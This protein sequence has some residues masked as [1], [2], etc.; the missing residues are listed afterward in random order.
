[1]IKKFL[2][3]I[4]AFTL[5]TLAASAADVWK[6]YAVDRNNPTK[7]ITYTADSA[8][9]TPGN[10][11]NFVIEVLNLG[12]A[13]NTAGAQLGDTGTPWDFVYPIDLDSVSAL[14]A[15]KLKELFD[16]PTIAISVG[17]R[18]D[19]A[20]IVSVVSKQAS[21]GHATSFL[22]EY[23][24]K[25]GDL[26]RPLKIWDDGAGAFEYTA[27][28][29]TIGIKNADNTTV[30][31]SWEDGVPDVGNA[32]G[33]LPENV[34][35]PP[36]SR[37]NKDLSLS[38]I[39]VEGARF[40]AVEEGAS[41]DPWRS[42]P[43]NVP[44]SAAIE[45]TGVGTQ[46]S[47]LYVWSDNEDILK[48]NAASNI[49]R[50]VKPEAGKHIIYNV[51]DET[52]VSS[53]YQLDF[54]NGGGTCGFTL[55]AQC[56]Y[57]A[58]NQKSAKVYMSPRIGI[59]VIEG[60]KYK[61]DF[62]T[63]TVVIA[64]PIQTK[65]TL[66]ARIDSFNKS[67]VVIGS[68]DQ[69]ALTLNFS[70]CTFEENIKVKF[71]VSYKDAEGNDVIEDENDPKLIVL[72]G[73]SVT[74]QPENKL[75]YEF[76]P[77]ETKTANRVYFYLKGAPQ[78][79]GTSKDRIICLKPTCY[80]LAGNKIDEV[81]CE[82]AYILVKLEA[83]VLPKIESI[84]AKDFQS[85]K[86]G[87]VILNIADTPRNLAF[88]NG[89]EPE[90][91]KLSA[92]KSYK[93][94]WFKDE[95][96]GTPFKTFDSFDEKD[97]TF[98]NG[99]IKLTGIVY[100]LPGTYTSRVVVTTPDDVVISQNVTVVVKERTY[101][102]LVRVD[103]KELSE[104]IGENGET[105][106]KIVLEPNPGHSG[107]LFAFIEEVDNL[108]LIDKTGLPYA[109]DNKTGLAIKSGET[110][111]FAIKF[112]DNGKDEE[113][114]EPEI[115]TV[116]CD[117]Y[118][119][120]DK[121]NRLE[122]LYGLTTNRLVVVNTPAYVGSFRVQPP[123][124]AS[125][126]VNA[127]G[128]SEYRVAAFTGSIK[129]NAPPTIK[130]NIVDVA[131]DLDGKALVEWRVFSR[132]DD[133]NL[134][135]TSTYYT[136]T[137][138]SNKQVTCPTIPEFNYLGKHSLEVRVLDKDQIADYIESDED[139]KW[140][141][142]PDTY[143]GQGVIKTPLSYD[144]NPAF[145]DSWGSMPKSRLDFEVTDNPAITV[146]LDKN[147]K[148]Q[149]DTSIK[150]WFEG[151]DIREVTITLETPARASE[152]IFN[153]EISRSD[154][155][156][157]NSNDFEILDN[158]GKSVGNTT[159]VSIPY[160]KQSGTFNLRAK[161][162]YSSSK[163]VIKVSQEGTKAYEDG[164]CNFAIYNLKPQLTISGGSLFTDD[165]HTLVSTNEVSVSAGQKCTI[166][167][168][169][170]D[171]SETSL[172]DWDGVKVIWTNG[173]TGKSET[174][175]LEADSKKSYDITFKQP[176]TENAFRTLTVKWYDK[177]NAGGSMTWKVK[178][179]PA[180]ILSLYPLGPSSGVSSDSKIHALF[181][182]AADS[183]SQLL[184]ARGRGKGEVDIGNSTDYS[185][186][187]DLDSDGA[188]R[189]ILG[190]ANSVTLK[191]KPAK[192]P[193]EIINADGEKEE[194]DSFF[195]T[196]L[197]A[198]SLED[199]SSYEVKRSGAPLTTMA[200]D[201]VESNK[202]IELPSKL[203]EDNASY[204]E[205]I[206]EAV[207]SRELYPSDNCGD[208]NGDGVPDIFVK[209]FGLGVYNGTALADDTADLTDLSRAN[210]DG[211]DFLPSPGSS[212]YTYN[213]RPAD[214]FKTAKAFTVVDEIRGFHRGLNE[215]R[216][217]KGMC[218]AA[219]S[220]RP[221]GITSDEDMSE[222]EIYAKMLT[223]KL[224]REAAQ[225]DAVT[226]YIKAVGVKAV[227]DATAA[228]EASLAA[229]NDG[230]KKWNDI[231]DKV[232]AGFPEYKDATAVDSDTYPANPGD[233]P[234]YETIRQ[235]AEE[236]A[237]ADDDKKN[238]VR[239]DAA[240]D[241]DANYFWS[242]ERPTD[243]T[244]ADTDGDGLLDGYEYWMWYRAHVGWMDGEGN[245]HRLG[246]GND[247]VY[248]FNILNPLEPIEISWREIE[249]HFDPLTPSDPEDRYAWDIDGDGISDIEEFAIGSNPVN[250]D[251]S[252]DGILDGWKLSKGLNIFTSATDPNAGEVN[253]D[254]DAYAVGN[255]QILYYQY[256]AYTGNDDDGKAIVEKR[257]RVYAH[258]PLEK[259]P[260]TAEDFGNAVFENAV[261]LD[262]E[263][264]S[265]VLS[266]YQADIWGSKV[267]KWDP[268]KGS[269]IKKLRIPAKVVTEAEI[270]E[271]K[272]ELDAIVVPEALTVEDGYTEGEILAR[273]EE[274]AET[275]AQRADLLAKFDGS[276]VGTPNDVFT[277]VI[278][279]DQV[280]KIYGFDPRTA[281]AAANYLGNRWDRNKNPDCHYSDAGR[282][283]NTAAFSTVMEF[284]NY[285][286]KRNVLGQGD[287]DDTCATIVAR[288]TNPVNRQGTDENG[289]EVTIYGADS[290]RDGLPD[291]WELYI[292][293]G[294]LDPLVKLDPAKV[295]TDNGWDGDGL[296]VWQEFC[297][298][299]SMAYY[300]DV[301][302]IQAF[303]SYRGE[304]PSKWLNKFF[305]TDPLNNDTDGDG[306]S[307]GAE[308]G[309]WKSSFVVGS[310]NFNG[311]NFTY[312]FVYG[313]PT[314]NG[315]CCIRGGGMNPCS[316]DTDFDGL[317][318]GWERQYA[319]LI[320]DPEG[321][322]N[323]DAYTDE[324]QISDGFK[325]GN[326]T[327]TRAF[328]FGGM[329]ATYAGDTHSFSGNDP[330]TGTSRDFDFDHDGLENF[331][332]YLTQAVRM[333][334]YD[335]A[336]TPLMG[337][338]ILWKGDVL[339]KEDPEEF[340]APN[341]ALSDKDLV[342]SDHF[343]PMNYTDA[344]AYQKKVNAAFEEV[345]TRKNAADE[346]DPSFNYYASDY[347]DPQK[348]TLVPAV[349]YD[350]ANLGYFALPPKDFD[351]MRFYAD[352]LNSPHYGQDVA[353]YMLRPKTL[354]AYYTTR[355]D[356]SSNGNLGP[357]RVNAMAYVSTDPRKWDS[358]GDGMDD[359]YEVFHGLNPLLGSVDLVG[360]AYPD[361]AGIS[362][363]MNAW[364]NWG[365][366]E[367]ED[368]AAFN[369][370]EPVSKF[371]HLLQPWSMGLPDADADDDGLRNR[372]E[373][374]FGLLAD[375]TSSHTDPSPAWMTDSSSKFSYV[376]MFYNYSPVFGQYS[377]LLSDSNDAINQYRG[378]NLNYAFS[379]EENEGYDTDGD[380]TS[381]GVELV[382][383]TSL[384]TDP[385][386]FT[387]P[388]RRQ[389]MYFDGEPK[390]AMMTKNFTEGWD[391]HTQDMFR[392]F[393]V[394]CYIRPE[395]LDKEQVLFERSALYKAGTVDQDLEVDADGN[396]VE[397]HFRANFR[398]G[399]NALGRVYALF[400][401]TRCVESGSGLS[402]E[403]I[404]GPI[405]PKD[406]WTHV[407]AT[408]DGL[409]FQLYINGKPYGQ[410]HKTTL[411]PANGI[412]L[413]VQDPSSTGDFPVQSYTYMRPG[414]M[415]IGAQ[416]TDAM[417]DYPTIGSMEFDA[418]KPLFKNNFKGY[419]DEVRIWDGARTAV[420]ID[421]DYKKSYSAEDVKELH[422]TVFDSWLS[423]A[424][425]NNND[426]KP[427]LPAQLIINIGFDSI[428]AA[429]DA[430]EV[431]QQPMG[432]TA[433]NGDAF[434]IGWWNK[435]GYRST[436]YKNTKVVPRAQNT[437]QHL[438]M[439][440]GSM[441]DSMY[442][443]E[444][445]AGN[446]VA[447]KHGVS[448][449][450]IPNSMNPY[451]SR[452]HSHDAYRH[453]QRTNRLASLGGYNSKA[454]KKY[455]FDLRSGFYSSTDFYPLGGAFAKTC[456]D[457]WDG[458]GASTVWTD[459]GMTIDS[460]VMIPQW[461]LKENGLTSEFTVMDYK[462]DE[463]TIWSN[464]S[465]VEAYIRDLNRGN[466][467]DLNKNGIPD[468][469]EELYGVYDANGDFDN[470]GLTNLQ[471]YLVEV[472]EKLRADP[473][474][475]NS[476]SD[477]VN[478]YFYVVTNKE[479]ETVKESYYLGF[480]YTDHDF[481]LDSVEA[482]YDQSKIS[483]SKYDPTVDGDNDGWSNWAE[484]TAG[485]D[486]TRRDSTG[487][488]G[489]QVS[490]YPIPALTVTIENAEEI[491]ET[492]KIVIRAWNSSEVSSTGDTIWTVGGDGRES[493]HERY[494]G[495]NPGAIRTY[496][497]SPGHLT[498]G[499]VVGKMFS[500]R[501]TVQDLE[502]DWSGTGVGRD[503]I[504][505]MSDVQVEGG[506][507]GVLIF[508]TEEERR[509][510]GT[511]NYETGDVV[512]DYTKLSKTYTTR[513]N[514]TIEDGNTEEMKA[515]Y[516]TRYNVA[517]SFFKFEYETT[518]SHGGKIATYYLGEADTG[519]LREGKND[520]VAFIDKDG[521]GTYTPGEPFG[522]VP[523]VQ[524]GWD[525]ISDLKL[526][527]SSKSDAINRFSVGLGD[528]A[529][530][531][532]RV[533]P[534]AINGVPVAKREA[535]LTTT[536]KNGGLGVITEADLDSYDLG[537]GTNDTKAAD[538][539][540]ASNIESVTYA[541]YIGDCTF[542]NENIKGEFTKT[543][544]KDR[545]K[546][547][548]LAPT[549]SKDAYV[550][551][552]C[553]T[554]SFIA[555]AGYTAYVAAI[556][557]GDGD[558]AK[559]TTI[560]NR[561][562]GSSASVQTFKSPIYFN[563]ASEQ[564]VTWKVQLLNAKFTA[565]VDADWSG[566][567]TF[568]V[569]ASDK[570][571]GADQLEVTTK[572]FGDDTKLTDKKIVVRAY[573]TADF[574]GTA[575]AE[576]IVDAAATATATMLRVPA[577]SYYVAAFIDGS[578]DSVRQPYE[579]W[580]Y[581]NYVDSGT[582]SLYNPRM[583]TIGYKV[584]GKAT[585]FIEDTD[586]NNNLKAD[587]SE[588]A[589]I[590]A[591]KT[592]S[593]GETEEPVT[594]SD[595]DGIPDTDETEMG[596]NPYDPSDAK[597][598]TSASD[599]MAYAEETMKIAVVTEKGYKCD[600]LGNLL[601]ANGNKISEDNPGTPVIDE[602]A[603]TVVK[604]Y[605]L[606]LDNAGTIYSALE[607]KQIAG[608]DHLVAYGPAVGL[609][610]ADLDPIK[611]TDTYVYEDTV[612]LIHNAVM[613]LKGFNAYTATA[614]TRA[615]R[616]ETEVD[617][618][619][620]GDV[621]VE[622][623][624]FTFGAP[625]TV[626][627][628][629]FWKYITA[630]VL[631][632][633]LPDGSALVYQAFDSQPNGL[634]DGWE[635]YTGSN[636]YFAYAYG[637]NPYTENDLDYDGIPT[638]WE[639]TH[640]MNPGSLSDGAFA[641]NE[642]DLMAYAEV[643]MTI[644]LT[645]NGDIYATKGDAKIG[646]LIKDGEF[647]QTYR[648]SSLFSSA[649]YGL[650][651]KLAP[652]KQYK[653][654][655]DTEGTLVY[656][657]GRVINVMKTNVALIHHQ[658]YTEFGFS[659]YTANP[660][661]PKKERINTKEFTP[662]DKYV[663][664]MFYTPAVTFAAPLAVDGDKDGL[665]D[666]W[667]L[668]VGLNP[669]DASDATKASEKDGLT[670]L[671]EYNRGELPTDPNTAH[672]Y[673]PEIT[674]KDVLGFNLQ[675]A[676]T[677]LTD[678]DNDGLTNYE[679]YLATQ[680]KY[681]TFD[682]NKA[683]SVETGKFDYF[684]PV[685]VGETS[686][687]V[688]FLITDHDMMAT[689]REATY[690]RSAIS[691]EKY[692]PKGDADQDGW[693]NYAEMTA[694]TDPTRLI[695]KGID[696]YTLTE[697]PIPHLPLELVSED[698][699]KSTDRIFITATQNGVT[700]AKWEIGKGE[701]RAVG[702]ATTTTRQYS[703]YVGM[704]PGVEKTFRLSPG[705]L[706]PRRFRIRAIPTLWEMTGKKKND[707]GSY[708]YKYNHRDIDSATWAEIGQDVM[709][710]DD[711]HT[712]YIRF[713][714]GT[715]QI[716]TINYTT[717]EVTIDFDFLY[718]ASMVWST[719]MSR[720]G[721]E[722]NPGD[723]YTVSSE[724]FFDQAY[725]VLEWDATPEFG[726][727]KS[728]YRLNDANEGF[729]REG[730]AD[731]TVF[732]DQ[733][734]NGTY[735]AGEPIGSQ[736][737][738]EI[739][740]DVVTGLK[741]NLAKSTTDLSGKKLTLLAPT[742]A[743][744]A[745]VTTS[746]PTFKFEA[747]A[748][749]ATYSYEVKKD[750]K[751]VASGTNKIN[752]SAAFDQTFRLAKPL[753][754]AGEYTWTV[755]MGGIT[756]APATFKLA[757]ATACPNAG[758]IKVTTKYAGAKDGKVIV[759][760]YESADFTGA[761]LAEATATTA[762]NGEVALSR[763]DAGSVYVV[764]FIDA[765]ANDV[766]NAFE[767]W[768]YVNFLGESGVGAYVPKAVK[769]EGGKT[770][771]VTI[772]LEDTDLNN[773]GVADAAEAD[774]SIF[775]IY[776]MTYDPT[777]DTDGDGIPN[778]D[779]ISL[780]LDPNDPTDAAKVASGDVMAYAEIEMTL[781]T[782]SDGTLALTDGEVQKGVAPA[783][784]LYA[785][786]AYGN[787]GVY[788]LGSKLDATTATVVGYKT[789]TVALVHDQVHAK[790]GFNSKTANPTVPVT[791][792]VNTKPF[793]ALDKYLVKIY[794]EAN[795]LG[796]IEAYI[797]DPLSSDTDYDDIP[798][799]WELYV[800]LRANDAKDALGDND[801]DGLLNKDEYNHGLV[802]NPHMKD[803]NG[804]GITDDLVKKWN[805]YVA[806]ADDD[807]D[808][809]SNYAEYLITEVF[810]FMTLDPKNA[811]SDNDGVS[812]YFEKVGDLYLGEIFTD[813]DQIDYVWE[814]Q[815]GDADAANAMV[816]DPMNDADGDGWT[817][818]EEFRAGTN[819]KA[820]E[821]TNAIH[822]YS[823]AEYPTPVV[824]ATIVNELA[825]NVGAI[826]VLAWNEADDYDMLKTPSAT[827]TFGDTTKSEVFE[828]YLGLMP[829]GLKTYYIGP[830]T[831]AGAS[832][833]LKLVDPLE[834]QQGTDPVWTAVAVDDADGNLVFGNTIVGS[835]DYKTGFVTIDFSKSIFSGEF[836]QEGEGED[837]PAKKLDNL[838]KC[839]AL[840]TW[841]AV[842][843]SMKKSVAGTYYLAEPD[844]AHEHLKSGK[845]TF[846]IFANLEE[847]DSGS[848]SGSDSAASTCSF[849][850]NLGDPMAIIR[851]VDVGWA[852]GEFDAELATTSPIFDRI[853]LIDGSS[854]R[855]VIY[856][857][858]GEEV[859]SS[860]DESAD[861]EDN[862]PSKVISDVE[863]AKSA[864]VQV[865]LKSYTDVNNKTWHVQ[866]YEGIYG[867]EVVMSKEFNFDIR[868]FLTEA[869]VMKSGEYDIAMDR[870]AGIITKDNPD[871]GELY[872]ATFGVRIV[873]GRDDSGNIKCVEFG[874]GIDRYFD[875]AQ[876]YDEF[877]SDSLVTK[878][879]VPE[880][881]KVN[882]SNDGYLY[883]AHPTFSWTM[884]KSAISGQTFNT[885]TAFCIEMMKVSQLGS[886]TVTNTVYTSG[887]Q[888][889]N[890]VNNGSYSWTAP[891][892]VGGQLPGGAMFESNAEYLWRVTMMNSKYQDTTTN[893]GSYSGYSVF[894]TAVNAQQP[895]NDHGYSS[896]EVKVNYYGPKAV[897]AKLAATSTVGKIR[898]QAFGSPDFVGAPAS[899]TIVKTNGGVAKLLGLKAG[900]Y[901][902][903]AYIDMDGDF[904]K[905]DW[906]SWGSCE[907]IVVNGE[908]LP[909]ASIVIED[910]D[911]DKDWLP[912]AWE[913]AVSG[914]SGDISTVLAQ[915]NDKIQSG[916]VITISDKLKAAIAGDSQKANFS[917]TLPG[918]SLTT[919]QS[920]DFAAALLGLDTT[921]KSSVDA[922]R[923]ALKEKVAEGSV[924]ITDF[925]IVDGKI[926]LNVA[927]ATENAI[928]D[929]L[930]SL[931]NRAASTTVTVTIYKKQSLA[932]SSWTYVTSETV[933][934]K[935]G[936]LEV[937]LDTEVETANG[938]FYTVTVE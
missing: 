805:L 82:E 581:Y 206:F 693:S 514:D 903:R 70:N 865:Y 618:G 589:S 243:P 460:N 473:C 876:G 733:N 492:D 182:G 586:L 598:S 364:N 422:N 521:S 612:I 354:V 429:D 335:D 129:K 837:K 30:Y 344:E 150:G 592:P 45:Y 456:E 214:W 158:N 633:T 426:D 113:G 500:A 660:S 509:E 634:P 398:L 123:S 527:L 194:Y 899:E 780:G 611:S 476:L 630:K 689:A 463:K 789:V 325:P 173:E 439:G 359:Y 197:V 358:D 579:S 525:K 379:F 165:N 767:S 752:G 457:M 171:G 274:I 427:T 713:G 80:D 340:V 884:P 861:D 674:D 229:F 199:S 24:V 517:D 542:A 546:A 659:P 72:G 437:V 491:V 663:T 534:T 920:A 649:T 505:V 374:I 838:R 421:S 868:N 809:L 252:G 326:I 322:S 332:E 642:N 151:N 256:W 746:T 324:L 43:A 623:P 361:A 869:D 235:K 314:D 886:K 100:Q 46:S 602:N 89:A 538:D 678:N 73:E 669:A 53:V 895:V 163:Y 211:D 270:D 810:K 472:G 175:T 387:D 711:P 251:C 1:M 50:P 368:L 650:G 283:V 44:V 807:G 748:N 852:G 201:G 744:D 71:E 883:G 179:I 916:T 651:E 880:N 420:D 436:V 116:L 131:S 731:F 225:D 156:D 682:V 177:D 487:V 614:R 105:M 435:S 38:M 680:A 9:F 935:P 919:F 536:I 347:V 440:D 413:I 656:D 628:T 822:G 631:G 474:N 799:G 906:E 124:K 793:T 558:N 216:A 676:A 371:D 923:E 106:F 849:G 461:W 877:G 585:I 58:E 535:V 483:A 871:R 907:P 122:D 215:F 804:D 715:T 755:T 481:M 393:T 526:Q 821:S 557:I 284:K 510:F 48:L 797:L 323:L 617:E 667:E 269:V 568:N 709:H 490:E 844:G 311:R 231:E 3:L 448:D 147:A 142:N 279:H 94:E 282:P 494:L 247:K 532:V 389:A 802:L 655:K 712:G 423:G 29:A 930:A 415:V 355:E 60:T 887:A 55:V 548:L 233:A 570:C 929:T 639:L 209:H 696:G 897:L 927:A 130:I 331:Q 825:A 287:D 39:C 836:L 245:Y 59:E 350:Y 626:A 244:K 67:E 832:V 771:T 652:S 931:Y 63:A 891:I 399:V 853:N 271:I 700:T 228:Y 504:T 637:Y 14:M 879:L 300:A 688:G 506:N 98:E 153:V 670:P 569:A 791:E 11:V 910:A 862:K 708:D 37:R 501:V 66:K 32:G 299:D 120:Y 512:L 226:A 78:P 49:L 431:S 114:K 905:S 316:I 239:A 539:A 872:K 68:E 706:D 418:T 192:T 714:N 92:N 90:N 681:G 917:A 547:T 896:I 732:V 657:N 551:E 35:N 531:K 376:S 803:T 65:P 922:I 7:E 890:V 499:K 353:V 261:L 155:G 121:T 675:T 768:G 238:S 169:I 488:Q 292:G 932:E 784:D 839:H 301:E 754:A 874:T 513:G 787:E 36:A 411:Q 925:S 178:V 613:Q 888:K 221:N 27:N 112:I 648:Y 128:D 736:T 779:E 328:I 735:D 377:W 912:D 77:D 562:N 365:K 16:K 119:R 74:V 174:Q 519:F 812:D 616:D 777:L 540:K 728:I 842:A 213:G 83:G 167:W 277:I 900:I 770:S 718:E 725:F 172:N 924:V 464:I 645:D 814:T 854:A 404:E 687:Y 937:K 573:D 381:D 210:D 811:D 52:K 665:P 248:R 453:Y 149:E 333:W 710:N 582:A 253:P 601:D 918:A 28:G 224:D 412:D 25:P 848:K 813:H 580:G 795:G 459:H 342:N 111:P 309:T 181:N 118:S 162:G 724:Y 409:T 785:T 885:Y 18:R 552:T 42:V 734:G 187:E 564:S 135:P 590:F 875:G 434:P 280:Y 400:D 348:F 76:T 22:C 375:P 742:A 5:S 893:N 860:T 938:E 321:N 403:K 502:Q 391:Y 57:D 212:G 202:R 397:A 101:A 236:D 207:F 928:A 406:A 846:M 88:T 217:E 467:T 764:A 41:L 237:D 646:D 21:D 647:Y 320:Y 189:W 402:S 99:K 366:N 561:I 293:S 829:T 587:A 272:A 93:V 246:Y 730:T 385:L 455:L 170:A 698:E 503:W 644:V 33:K 262:N 577:G 863:N 438:A 707:D 278:W 723:G 796:P 357:G 685:K 373:A 496:H 544:D 904:V 641:A 188:K 220:I 705:N 446:T 600:E 578:G 157:Y 783:A 296:S 336:E 186:P 636:D 508:G 54:T 190:G 414:A 788:G 699:I 661:V 184:G 372:E 452:V 926:K 593:T 583:V 288:T 482:G 792:Q 367:E 307:D 495:K 85:N 15:D 749:C 152:T 934:V 833:D 572:Y 522:Y 692:D 276:L 816:Y 620:V 591:D 759:R 388:K 257:Y 102:K 91:E 318:D 341:V 902:L 584:P 638:S 704:N 528:A 786:Y 619:E 933:T 273:D 369:A 621:S 737:G 141:V 200:S 470:D 304:N 450:N 556:T 294:K 47:P 160:G 193:I 478:D 454:A 608:V 64:E 137:P 567:A 870:I 109:E 684:A 763:V 776:D 471:E 671:Q 51:D 703:M 662:F 794:A 599:V 441:W 164:E 484:V 4:A 530:A 549:A 349:K 523:N 498:P 921:N 87:K 840:L 451:A 632:L 138:I 312:G 223:T 20:T 428:P 234:N 740:W 79:L 286:Y 673:D 61:N 445:V 183:G 401:S 394:E 75:E 769:V 115:A 148:V 727:S 351:I 672:T 205:T 62:V 627:F 635:L 362:S 911:T 443:T 566:E 858:E 826:K 892:S 6:L 533:V 843:N 830:G 756:S 334:R 291:G 726:G 889:I 677:R 666:G 721:R 654:A 857:P 798:D 218:D 462:F 489:V 772:F 529:W 281:W 395:V 146:S 695:T 95:N 594:D 232:A 851:G 701:D 808:G 537:F 815:V 640:G 442:W 629:M 34:M 719:D 664:E 881:L 480:K 559:T 790:F 84:E 819:P 191:A 356:E 750:A 468:W 658:V 297:G 433:A 302:T 259:M 17:G 936:D 824:K 847:S 134:I 198:T 108:N 716:G 497:L 432:F 360:S 827:W 729:L 295:D 741:I 622:M 775:S 781:V 697:H 720:A 690:D 303:N 390:T 204:P 878:R 823:F 143:D 230:Y 610:F 605:A 250:Y 717:G 267:L 97:D 458:N 265:F 417:I 507:E 511:V 845:T 574:T 479:G 913:Y 161:D 466:T 914:W 817:N 485:T 103:G 866:Q 10:T 419:I 40:T 81:N 856:T 310:N 378:S 575:V 338:A 240:A 449:Y 416:I 180:K 166:N 425:R 597:L 493:A 392:Q 263:A 625:D 133:N 407:A 867:A 563:D 19:E 743:A 275:K 909:T 818:Y 352:D 104:A 596:L 908:T 738:V 524:V 835:V 396:R 249:R 515:K 447:S 615:V 518:P 380:W 722:W 702:E 588:E 308:N 386:N 290:D 195:Y 444:D 31:P 739:G 915:K 603:T 541:I 774:T 289:N 624:G 766:H 132:D 553:P 469:W 565:T 820:V 668:Y 329:D 23:I 258:K 96:D 778:A 831:I 864:I 383:S 345:I 127:V 241:F 465:P 305:P 757:E 606:I 317:P 806:G 607:L 555:P 268:S 550:Y 384:P 762:K 405:L 298:V 773:N 560:T 306:V 56:A 554:F 855:T 834:C 873:D 196:W 520:F 516:R 339:P 208:I 86:A 475:A 604:K 242:P 694:G 691:T 758:T 745:V 110:Q 609:D 139:N 800:G 176:T 13:Y 683:D 576:A 430:T 255:A 117:T 154:G 264:K 140:L 125:T 760:A 222:A 382:K 254:G 408:Y 266:D 144:D 26:A 107:D 168:A 159:T 343:I 424:T 8:P 850:Y 185:Q 571:T 477:T 12:S 410:P 761:I 69:H 203:S 486:P 679:E 828:K 363:D 753:D 882:N 643:E 751:V 219:S 894:K 901:Y 313:N 898:V 545:A 330:F 126:T 136:Y 801:G 337:R 260:L 227:E 319:G 2:S 145:E 370:G 653:D 543:F 327:A 841:T 747:I 686:T 346:V 285:W 859:S 595:G 765:N 315:T 782:L